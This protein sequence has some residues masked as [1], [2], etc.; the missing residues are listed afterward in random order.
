M[1]RHLRPRRPRTTLVVATA[2]AA[3]ALTGGGV[4]LAA[5]ADESPRETIRFVVK[6]G[7]ADDRTTDK[8]TE[9]CPGGNGPGGN[10]PGGTPSADPSNPATAL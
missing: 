1:T 10:G 8:T 3:A 4:A 7:P 5:D 6:E 9:D 2:L